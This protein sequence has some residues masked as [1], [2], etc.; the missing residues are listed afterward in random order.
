MPLELYSN[1]GNCQT[2]K[3]LLFLLLI[4]QKSCFLCHSQHKFDD[5]VSFTTEKKYNCVIQNIQFS[6]MS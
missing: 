1:G 6:I 4:P 2:R 3:M 5:F